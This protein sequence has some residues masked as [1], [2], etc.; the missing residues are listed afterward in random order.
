M[1]IFY[2]IYQIIFALPALLV[3]TILTALVTIIGSLVGSAH[4]WGYY[5]G[6]IWSQLVCIILLIPVKVIGREKLHPHTSYV[7]VPNHQ[8]AFDIFLVYGYLGRNFKWMMKKGLRSIPF[9]GKACESA[10]HIFVDRS[11]PRKILATMQKA[12]ASLTH[13]VSVVVFPEGARTFT[14]HMGYF[15]RGAFQLADQLQL[16]VVPIT[17]DGSFEILPRT[18]KWIH[19]H[20][21]IMTIHDPIPPKGKGAENI[22]H[23]LE[24][25]YTAVESALPEKFKGMVRNE[26]QDIIS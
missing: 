14:G 12:K 3:L 16:A 1:K 18:G 24:E 13:G 21:M 26:D 6:K 22:H 19:R 5:P 20:R 2:I 9:V 17:I 4:F 25:A 8:G 15:K 10:G 11:S 23:T 7:F